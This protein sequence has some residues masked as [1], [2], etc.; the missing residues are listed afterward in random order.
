MKKRII[1]CG[2]PKSGNTWLTRLTAEVI[3]CPVAGFWCQPGNQEEAIEG[4]DRTSDFQ[5][6][7]AHHAIEQLQ[8]TLQIYGNG[9]EKI[10]YIMRDP[11]DV[12]VS[13]TYYFKINPRFKKLYTS[14]SLIPLGSRGY[15]KIWHSTNYK[16]N[17]WT[18]GL[19]E[20]TSEGVWLKTPWKKHVQGFCKTNILMVRYEDLF[21]NP[22]SEIAKIC[23]YL[24]ID[25][26]ATHIKNAIQNQSFATK[27]AKFLHEGQKAKAAFLRKGKCGGWK[28]FLS[29][30]QC[31]M[32]R[33]QIGDF[34][35]EFGYHW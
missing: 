13:L 12:I 2:Y 6:F 25:R 20:G 4:L 28:E 31:N 3:K 11:R 7:K 17:T 32:I 24:Q 27:K 35:A 10:I 1:I 23:Q 5:C 22:K 16:L 21:T 18:I 34:M 26:C 29:P 14:L 33:D 8:N 19:L 30:V 9:T 15:Y